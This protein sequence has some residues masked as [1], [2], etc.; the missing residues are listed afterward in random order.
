MVFGACVLKIGKLTKITIKGHFLIPMLDDI[1]DK[2]EGSKVFS[3]L[4]L[5]SGY[6][7]M[8]I[9]PSDDQKNGFKIKK[10]VCEWKMMPFRL[11]KAL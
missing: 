4:D 2:L 5:L 6:H 7:H 1:F 3:R 10:G 8:R 11:C 9:R